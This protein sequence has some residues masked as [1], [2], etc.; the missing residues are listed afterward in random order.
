[1]NEIECDDPAVRA[2]FD[3]VTRLVIAKKMTYQRGDDEANGYCCATDSGDDRVEFTWLV[4]CCRDAADL[5]ADESL[6]VMFI[7]CNDLC[8][9]VLFRPEE[10]WSIM[11][12]RWDMP[13]TE[14]VNARA[15]FPTFTAKGIPIPDLSPGEEEAEVVVERSVAQRAIAEML[16]CFE[17][18]LR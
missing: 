15:R 13:I 14:L 10:H 8:L 17:Q 7:G 5:N 1:M 16:D 11:L 3:A 18:R 9:E 12:S 6:A 2:E 4:I